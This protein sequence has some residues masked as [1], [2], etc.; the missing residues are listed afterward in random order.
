MKNKL[1][2]ISAELKKASKT[3]AGQ[4]AKIDK[5]IKPKMSK[6][7]KSTRKSMRPKMVM[8]PMLSIK[9]PK[10][11]DGKFGKVAGKVGGIL[12]LAGQALGIV[13]QVKQLKQKTPKDKKPDTAKVAGRVTKPYL[14]K[15]KVARKKK[16]I[17]RKKKMVANA[18][19]EII[20]GKRNTPRKVRRA[21][22]DASRKQRAI[23][24]KQKK[25][26]DFSD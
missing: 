4:A 19:Q 16:A 13:N 10:K 23:Y 1:K 24:R 7:H 15:K 6:L 9:K 3:H 25:I 14:S 17:Q 2:A 12:G 26:N 18:A 21:L 11:G 5:L 8:K 20:S 22:K